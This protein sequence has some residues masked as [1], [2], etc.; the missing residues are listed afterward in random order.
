MDSGEPDESVRD[1]F[2]KAI[3]ELQTAEVVWLFHKV[4]PVDP[5]GELVEAIWVSSS[6]DHLSAQLLRFHIFLHCIASIVDLL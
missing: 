5:S 6:S 2:G 4:I 1:P 3:R